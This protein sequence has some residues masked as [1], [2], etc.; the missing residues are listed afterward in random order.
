MKNIFLMQVSVFILVG[1]FGC[2]SNSNAVTQVT[3]PNIKP[4]EY[5]VMVSDVKK[6]DEVKKVFAKYGVADFKIITKDVVKV[7][8]KKD[9]GFSVLKRTAKKY[10]WIRAIEPNR[11]VKITGG[12]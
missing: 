11:V 2:S 4:K 5:L 9:P 12:M 8:F 10:K 7:T 6:V 1:L 3:T